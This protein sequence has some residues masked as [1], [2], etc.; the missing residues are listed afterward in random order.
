MAIRQGRRH[1]PRPL[2]SRPAC[3]PPFVTFVVIGGDGVFGVIVADVAVAVVSGGGGGGVHDAGGQKR[4]GKGKDANQTR[5]QTHGVLS[6]GQATGV[7]IPLP[8]SAL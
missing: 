3:E 4:S 7:V 1:R 8:D 6:I 2:P 5:N